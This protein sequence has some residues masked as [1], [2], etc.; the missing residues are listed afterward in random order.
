MSDLTM[1]VVVTLDTFAFQ[2]GFSSEVTITGGG[3]T[4]PPSG[5]TINTSIQP[6]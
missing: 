2:V 6:Q 1:S 4:E 3:V 5:S